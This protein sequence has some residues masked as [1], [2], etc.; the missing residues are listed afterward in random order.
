ML[1]KKYSYFNYGQTF[2]QIRACRQMR[3]GEMKQRQ[4]VRQTG[5][6]EAFERLLSG[7]TQVQRSL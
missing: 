4:R 5:E 3:R 6:S 1:S 7:V 2:L